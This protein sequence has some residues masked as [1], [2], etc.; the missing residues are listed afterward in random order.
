MRVILFGCD[1]EIDLCSIYQIYI[2]CTL[3]Y[4]HYKHTCSFLEPQTLE[5]VLRQMGTGKMIQEA[6]IQL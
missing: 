4:H 5:S 6:D 2:V 3:K 1:I